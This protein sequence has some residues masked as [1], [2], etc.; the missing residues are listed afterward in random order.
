MSSRFFST[1]N[2]KENGNLLDLVKTEFTVN[3]NVYRKDIDSMVRDVGCFFLISQLSRSR[4]G[5]NQH[6]MKIDKGYAIIITNK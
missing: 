4:E 2:D 5:E 1:N 6:R 3:D